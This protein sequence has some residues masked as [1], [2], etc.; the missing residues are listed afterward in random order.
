MITFFVNSGY[1]KLESNNIRQ[2][3]KDIIV[4]LG[5]S[6]ADLT[7]KGMYHVFIDLLSKNYGL[8]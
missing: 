3:C 6:N 1:T 7:G 2:L 5:I 4:Y 8:E